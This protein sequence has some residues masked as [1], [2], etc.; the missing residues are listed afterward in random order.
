MENVVSSSDF[1]RARLVFDGGGVAI[2]PELGTPR[3]D[4]MQGTP[5]EQLCEVGGRTCYDSLGKG[6][7]SFTVYAD[8]P[9]DKPSD[10]PLIPKTIQGYHD[11]I[12]QVG[13][14]SVWEH[15]N[16]TAEFPVGVSRSLNNDPQFSDAR[17]AL[18][19]WNCA[20]RPGVLVLGAVNPKSIRV[21]LNLRC[22]N[23]WLNWSRQ[24]YG[25]ITPMDVQFASMFHRIGHDLAPHIIPESPK[26]GA[27]A[28]GQAGSASL[29]EYD[30]FGMASLSAPI[31][32]NERWISMFMA[33]SRGLSH[34]LVRHGDFTAISQ[35]STR[36]VDESESDWVEHP[37]TSQ[38]MRDHDY[39]PGRYFEQDAVR[40]AK[41]AYGQTVATLEPWLISRGCLDTTSAR[42]QARGAARGYLGNA[43]YTELIFS[44]N[45]AQWKRML[46]QRASQFADAEIRELFCKSL[47]ELKQSRYADS[48]SGFDLI[49]SPDGIGQVAVENGRVA[50]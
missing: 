8:P 6:R 11:H 19:G 40:E 13:H 46:R 28:E 43:L 32:D 31:S 37:L 5:A 9:G 1:I 29:L 42:K 26:I 41:S 38:Y 48:F 15:F 36:F 34:E 14:G 18:F 10:R 4:Q 2:P 3:W 12:A 30:E 45:V 33:G 17:Q 21:T 16:F 25:R 23:E 39:R 49:A 27:V 24:L 47:V 20:N 22:V 35:R 7:P 50:P 44:A